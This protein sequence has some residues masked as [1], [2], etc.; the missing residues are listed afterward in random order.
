MP[1][2][3]VVWKGN[4]REPRIRY[5]LLGHLHRLAA[6]S[7]EYLRLRPPERPRVLNMLNEERRGAVRVRSN[8]E[9][10]DESV[11]GRIVVSSWIGPEP[12]KLAARAREAGA[13]VVEETAANNAP[14]IAISNARLRGLD[15][16]LFDPRG[17]YPGA[18]RMSFVFLECPEYPFLDGR[19]VEIATREEC[20]T[21]GSE[22]LTGADLY[23]CA[24][25][26][27]LRYYLEDWTDC[28]FSWIKFFFV[29]DFWWHRWAELQGYTDY[30]QVFEDLQ[31]DR[32]SEAAEQSAFDAV[33]AT[34]SQHAEHWIGEVE[35]WAKN[36]QG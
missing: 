27:H 4:C 21:N 5:R 10:I 28:L 33:L 32:G 29:G 30:R 2:V 13:I 24:P 6:R 3:A 34:F 7:D 1:S 36:E 23:L 11:S 22:A 15:F 14:L 19:L 16:K 26:V 12:A 18:D 17:L 25:S 31:A 20:A 9:T 8:V 35:G